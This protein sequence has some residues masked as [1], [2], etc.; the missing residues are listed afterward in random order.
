MHFDL[1][2]IQTL[3]I[4]IVVLFIGGF[5]RSRLPP[6]ERFN[7]PAPVIG[8]IVFA[9]L[10]SFLFLGLEVEISF[11]ADLRLPLMLAFFTSIGLGADLRRLR[12]GG[13]KLGVF[14]LAAALF[15]VAQNAVGI[16]AALLLDLHPL[17]GLLSSSITLSG[18][19]GTGAAYA[20]RFAS[21]HNLRGAMELAMACATFGLV[22]GGLIGGP[23]AH[24]LISRRG[25]APAPDDASAPLDGDAGPD[26]GAMSAENMLGALFLIALCLVVG[27]A[28]AERLAGAGPTLPSFVW[29]LLV[30]VAIR[31]IAEASGLW[32][33]PLASIELLGSVSLSLFLAMALM[34][35]RLW[36][37][38]NLAG[39]LLAVLAAQTLTMLLFA[40][41]VTFRLM[42]GDYTAAVI[43]S[44][45]CGFGLGATPT[46]VANMEAVTAR[47]GPAPTAYIVIP[48]TG[49]F[50][51]DLANALVLGGYLSL[52]LFGFPS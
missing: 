2:S 40:G 10:T 22:I 18:G 46:A 27:G 5:A 24:W 38:A 1:D 8:G 32:T 44:G 3:M 19:H 35:L 7:I 23:L 48:L 30:G 17:V 29:A 39:P 20:E 13:S 21:I 34:A 33:L 26:K 50:F 42:G 14:L 45:H 9:L 41:L 43:C 47:F 31:N 12:R 36:E 51:I 25:L 37:L 4:A 16:G 6:L 15:L 49:A 52:P 11:D 28:L